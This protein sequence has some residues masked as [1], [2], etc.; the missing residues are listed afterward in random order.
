VKVHELISRLQDE[1]EHAEV[2]FVY[3]S[4][5]PLQDKVA[6]VWV[7]ER[8]DDSAEEGVVYIVSGGQNNEMPYGP[9][10]AFQEAW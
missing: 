3:Q 6:G 7:A 2:R 10:A 9:G 5:Y 1:N 4:N 8:G